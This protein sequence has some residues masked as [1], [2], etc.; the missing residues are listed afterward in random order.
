MRDT[1]AG[2]DNDIVFALMSSAI[3]QMFGIALAAVINIGH[4]PLPLAVITAV[5]IRGLILNLNLL[6]LAVLDRQGAIFSLRQTDNGF[7]LTGSGV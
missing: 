4:Q 6:G 1:V 3:N 5:Q 7:A 2:T